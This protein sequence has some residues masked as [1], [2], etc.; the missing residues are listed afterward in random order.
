MKRLFAVSALLS[1]LLAPAATFA[2]PLTRVDQAFVTAYQQQ[3]RQVQSGRIRAIVQVQA[4]NPED[5]ISTAKSV[6]VG[7]RSG[8]TM[9]EIIEAQ[10]EAVVDQDGEVYEATVQVLGITNGLA[11]PHYC[12]EQAE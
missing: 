5:L 2:R 1:V 11:V 7:L 9:D 3:A 4:T 12:P 10:V 6:C 8:L